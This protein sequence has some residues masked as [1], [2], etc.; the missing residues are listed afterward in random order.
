MQRVELLPDAPVVLLDWSFFV[1]WRFFATK[2]WH[3]RKGT[4]MEEPL[5]QN[6]EFIQD[7]KRT[8]V[9]TVET[10]RR[11]YGAPRT[12]VVALMDSPRATLW[13]KQVLP[14]YKDNRN[15]TIEGGF[16]PLAEA[17]HAEMGVQAIRVQGLE[18]DDLAALVKGRLLELGVTDIVMLTDDNDWG[19]LADAS[20]GVRIINKD[21]KDIGVRCGDLHQKILCGD[22]GDNIPPAFARC[23]KATAKRYAENPAALEDYF[24][25]NPDARTT[26]ERNRLLIDL[27]RIPTEHVENFRVQVDLSLLPSAS[28]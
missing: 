1:F 12:N 16:F 23:G 24:M 7:F 10:L 25:K 4:P 5:E 8:F 13:R 6:A 20:R 26:Y 28:I 18:A 19:Q 21:E 17:L 3:Q 15:P 9:R 14:T 2:S 11:K 27:S 22:P